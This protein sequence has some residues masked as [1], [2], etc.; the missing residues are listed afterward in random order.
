M[1]KAVLFDFDGVLVDSEK[2][3]FLGIKD[4]LES[5]GITHVIQEDVKM[6]TGAGEDFYFDSI[7]SKWNLKDS[8]EKIVEIALNNFMTHLKGQTFFP[9]LIEIVTYLKSHNIKIAIVTSA[10]KTLTERKMKTLKLDFSI[11]DLIVYG[12][13]VSN[14]KPSPD[15]YMFAGKQLGVEMKDCLV[16][17]DALNGV[18]AGKN[19][20]ALVMGYCSSIDG[21]ELI[22]SGAD[23]ICKSYQDIECI[24][25][26][27]TLLNSTEIQQ[28]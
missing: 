11:F 12:E 28:L 7:R 3:I 10:S 4:Y 24:Q 9:G 1:I 19:S 22:A 15:I 17:E 5:L 26:F 2:A 21:K 25:I 14:N 13:S 6:F 8:R 27:N 23:F 20:G 18:K 16:V